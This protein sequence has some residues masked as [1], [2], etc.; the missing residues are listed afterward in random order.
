MSRSGLKRI[1]DFFEKNEYYIAMAII[2]IVAFA[3]FIAFFL[4]GDGPVHMGF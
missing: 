2:I 4:V 1:K 3:F